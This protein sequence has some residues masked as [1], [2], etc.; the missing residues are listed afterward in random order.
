MSTRKVLVSGDVG[1]KWEALFKRVAAVNKSNGPFDCLFCIGGSF[2]P[3]APG[4]DSKDIPGELVE[5]IAGVK[6]PPVTT[7]FIGAYGEREG[8]PKT[9]GS[10]A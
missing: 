6:K 1:G 9:L 8:A 3:A 4:D 10:F 7:Y 5:Y 2:A